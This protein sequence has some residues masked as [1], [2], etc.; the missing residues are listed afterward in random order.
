LFVKAEADLYTLVEKLPKNDPAW[1]LLDAFD[2][3]TNG[4]E[5]PEAMRKAAQ[6]SGDEFESWKLLVRAIE[7]MYWG[8]AELCLKTA[9]KIPADSAPACLKPLFGAWAALRNG[10]EK[11][12][13]S[14]EPL[15]ALYDKLIIKP[16]PLSLLAEQAEEAVRQGLEEQFTALSSRVLGGLKDYSEEAALRYSKRCMELL[17]EEGIPAAGFLHA[18]EKIL[19]SSTMDELKK[20]AKKGPRAGRREEP[21]LFPAAVSSGTAAAPPEAGAEIQS[22]QIPPAGEH[23]EDFTGCLP[24]ALRFL[25]PGAWIKAIKD[26]SKEQ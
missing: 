25:G 11:Q 12:A 24:P 13:P 21:S 8:K 1:N 16:H 10:G 23:F 3:V 5:N 14:G 19:K 4:M 22:G 26:S 15:G 7:A 20:A 9:E 2:A 17:N 6:V 18:A